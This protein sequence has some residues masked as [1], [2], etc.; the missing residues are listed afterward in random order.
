MSSLWVGSWN[1]TDDVMPM[2]GVLRHRQSSDGRQQ[3][4]EQRN[5]GKR[6]ERENTMEGAPF[7]FFISSM[8]ET[9]CTHVHKNTP[10]YLPEDNQPG[11][12]NV[13]FWPRVLI[14]PFAWVTCSPADIYRGITGR[15]T[16]VLLKD[17][18]TISPVDFLFKPL[19]PPV[20]CNNPRNPEI[21]LQSPPDVSPHSEAWWKLMKPQGNHGR[22][23]CSRQ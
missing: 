23:I 16:V 14:R 5:K 21:R 2:G 10:I 8:W 19:S 13:S 22:I 6:N 4:K 11:L 7:L 18:I 3:R 1:R 15:G 12:R 20:N 17:K 9:H